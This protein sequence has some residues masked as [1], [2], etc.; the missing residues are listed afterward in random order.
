MPIA[1][2]TGYSNYYTNGPT[3]EN[4]GIEARLT[5]VPVKTSDFNWELTANWAKNVN[6]VT[7]IYLDSDYLPL[8]SMWNVQ[9]GAKL[10]QSTGTLLGTNYVYLNGQRVV[11]S[12]GKYLISDATNEVIGDATPDWTGSLINNFRYKN[13]NL[14]L[15]QFLES[16]IT[17]QLVS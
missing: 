6:K 16:K 4:K 13:F 3:V 12:N 17:L 10:G 15:N 9:T 2:S 8:A 14:S 1:G 5:V 7:R 11:G